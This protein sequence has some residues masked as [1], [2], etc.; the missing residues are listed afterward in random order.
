MAGRITD[1][2]VEPEW[3]SWPDRKLLDMRFC[4]LK[5]SIRGSALQTR[6][7]Q[8][9]RELKQIG[10]R[11]RPFFWISLEWFT[12]DGVPGCAAPFYLIHPRLAE[13]EQRQIGEVEGGTAEWCMRILR[14]ETGHAIDNAYQL[15]RRM[16]RQR[17]FGSPQVPYPEFYEPRPY[18]RS[19]V[20]HLEPSYAQSHPDEDFAETFAVWMTPHST[21]RQRYA[22]W[23]ALEK[24]EYMDELMNEV[25][26]K[27]PVNTRHTTVEPLKELKTTLREHY[28]ARRETLGIGQDNRY[29]RDLRRLFPSKVDDPAAPD[30][31]DRFIAG[32]Q[33]EAVA[34][35]TR[36]TGEYKY[37]VKRVIAEIRARCRT[38][39]LGIDPQ[40]AD[41]R[42]NFEIFLT[43]Q[44]MKY[45]L[46]GR[47]R[48]WL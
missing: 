2:T 14:H 34:K 3:A 5:L 17:L 20:V 16:R 48:E 26:D 27:P 21:W 47:H 31:A 38:L 13:L 4:D 23:R 1:T 46:Q 37:M 6:I 8:L 45:V 11:F 12:P 33:A 44:T 40:A 29:D 22:S 10:F 24:L 32:I 9:Y 35:V 15:R 7:E 43:A 39:G 30:A 28:D 41:T 18:S 25:R 19:F 42:N 36:W